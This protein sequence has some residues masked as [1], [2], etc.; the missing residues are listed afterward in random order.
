V[1]ARTDLDGTVGMNAG[2]IEFCADPETAV[3]F[4]VE[5]N[6]TFS[7]DLDESELVRTGNTWATANFDAA[8]RAVDLRLEGN[9]ASFSLNPEGGCE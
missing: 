1:D 9:A 5:E 4:T 3:R 7:H 6:L 2:S 8:D